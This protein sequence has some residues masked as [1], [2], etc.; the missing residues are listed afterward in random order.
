MLAQSMDSR[1]EA[2]ME[3]WRALPPLVQ[4]IMWTVLRVTTHTQANLLQLLGNRSRK[5]AVHPWLLE[6][7]CYLNAIVHGEACLG[8]TGRVQLANR[9][10]SVPMA[11]ETGPS[12]VMELHT[13]YASQV[14]I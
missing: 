5:P 7:A 10:L 11:Q 13:I 3:R 9:S 14:H 12:F 8:L 6:T 2:T 4:P 1:M